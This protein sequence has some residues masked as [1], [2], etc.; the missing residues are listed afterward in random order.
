MVLAAVHSKAVILMLLIHCLLL[1][2]MRVYF[3]VLNPYLCDVVLIVVYT[4]TNSVCQLRKV[5]PEPVITFN[6]CIRSADSLN[7][8]QSK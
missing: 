2:L 8:V 3:F 1:L 7:L 6:N 5:N 4:S